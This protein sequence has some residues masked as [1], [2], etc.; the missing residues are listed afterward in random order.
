[1]TGKGELG[2]YKDFHYT[3]VLVYKSPSSFLSSYC[4]FALN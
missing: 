4:L 1:L 2:P 3:L